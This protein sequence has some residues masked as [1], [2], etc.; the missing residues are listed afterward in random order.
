MANS[1]TEHSKKLRKTTAAKRRE[2]ILECGGRDLRVLLEPKE[3]A[4]LR[5]IQQRLGGPEKPETA[6]EVINRLIRAKHVAIFP[7]TGTKCPKTREL[8]LF[9]VGS[10]NE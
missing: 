7:N 4:M 3:A 5:E 6:T 10:E 1:N 9:P 8:I 2:K